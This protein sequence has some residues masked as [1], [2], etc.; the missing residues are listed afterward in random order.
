MQSFIIDL[1]WLAILFQPTWQH[2]SS[3]HPFNLLYIR[4]LV[5]SDHLYEIH[6]LK[7]LSTQSNHLHPHSLPIVP[8]F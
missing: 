3:V 2:H 4:F 1:Q 5:I 8:R 6:Q 7:V